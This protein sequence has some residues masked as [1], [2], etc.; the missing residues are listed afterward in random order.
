MTKFVDDETR[1]GTF[2]ITGG[3]APQPAGARVGVSR[4]GLVRGEPHLPIH[5]YAVVESPSLEHAT[6][7]AS[8]L[9]RLHQRHAPAWEI[10]CDVREIVTNCLP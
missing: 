9:L 5:G 3:L 4:A 7:A 6:E 2:V 1:A 8:R 10:E